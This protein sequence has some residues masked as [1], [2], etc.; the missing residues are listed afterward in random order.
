MKSSVSNNFKNAYHAVYLKEI[1]YLEKEL[2][3]TKKMIKIYF[4]TLK[5]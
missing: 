5:I 2:S 1:E 4:K 3:S